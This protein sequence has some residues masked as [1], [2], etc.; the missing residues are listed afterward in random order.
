LL[1]DVDITLIGAAS[2][3]MAETCLRKQE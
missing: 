3:V 1:A 2:S